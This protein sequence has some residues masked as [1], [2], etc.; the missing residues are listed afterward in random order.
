[1][2]R[3]ILGQKGAARFKVYGLFAESCAKNGR[4]DRDAVWVVD[5]GGSKE[6]C[7]RWG[8]RWRNL[9]NTIE[10]SVCGT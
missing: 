5:S 4:T 10:P 3:A 9:A 6:A 8:A 1:M 7:I 2:G